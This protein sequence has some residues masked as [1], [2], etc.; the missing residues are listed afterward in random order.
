[1]L[2]N[3]VYALAAYPAGALTDRWPRPY[4]YACGLLAFSVGYLGLGLVDA[5]GWAIVLIAVYGLFPAFTDGVG[6]AWI[7]SLVP[8][9]HRGRAQGVYQALTSGAVLF[10]GAWAGL[11]WTIGPGAGVIPLLVA[12]GVGLAAAMAMIGLR[13]SMGRRR[14]AS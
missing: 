7:S 5:G 6:K 11:L 12:G 10:A 8:D 4:V 14:A 9:D 3:L 1:A 2:F 13:L